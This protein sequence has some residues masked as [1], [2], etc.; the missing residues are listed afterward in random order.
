[1]Q[2]VGLDTDTRG[3]FTAGTSLI[4]VP[5]GIKV[6]SWLATLTGGK[7]RF[8]TSMMF[9]YGFLFMFTVG[10]VTGVVLANS[11]IDLAL[12]DTYFVTAHFHYVLSMGAIF[13]GLNGW[14]Y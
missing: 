14:Y 13:G 7:I 8:S 11:S 12:H 4:A 1:M 5:T 6:F 10:G 2:T 3:Y 9:G